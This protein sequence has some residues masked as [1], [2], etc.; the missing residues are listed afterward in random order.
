MPEATS[1]GAEFGPWLGVVA[2]PKH[3]PAPG[4]VNL[5][6]ARLALVQR[7]LEAAHAPAPDWMAAWDPVID[8][9]SQQVVDQVR[10]GA[11]AAVR[12]SLAPER[13]VRTA[14]PDEDDL[15]I[16]RAQIGSAGIPLE[17]AAAGSMAHSFA[18]IGGAVEESWLALETM[19]AAVIE[20]WRPRIAAV[21][22]WRRPTTGL[23]IG[24]GVGATAAIGVGLVI[25]GYLPAPAWLEPVISWWWSLPW[26]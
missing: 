15:R 9:V 14:L 10:A 24:T 17:Q 3:R 7:F 26:P 23:W 25:G 13:V 4:R 19:V 11:T 8:S 21:A 18:T 20:E 5:D 2:S 1:S 6:S 16:L 22:A 12:A